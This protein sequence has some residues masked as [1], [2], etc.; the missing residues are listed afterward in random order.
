MAKILLVE[1]ERD[2]A[3]QLEDWFKR[4]QHT[5][6]VA[7]SGNEALSHLQSSKYDLVILDWM[8]PHVSGLEVLQQMRSRNNRTPVIMLTAKDSEDDKEKGLD[9]GADDYVTKPFSL[10]E[11]SARTR[12][13]LRRSSQ[14]AKTV[15]TAG[16]VE[17]DPISR[18]VTRGSVEVHLEPRE[19][20]LLE[21]FMRHPQQVFSADALI[22]RVWPSDTLISTDAIRTYIKILRKKLDNEKSIQNVRGVGYKF[23]PDTQ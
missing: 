22:D 16:D 15:L 1:D 13:A 3:K 9:S 19:F 7:Y 6:E 20:N 5:I 4:E 2:L 11:L 12:A 14:A 21:F 17:L 18:T 23:E 8:L 10:R